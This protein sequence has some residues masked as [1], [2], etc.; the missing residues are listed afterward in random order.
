MMIM[1]KLLLTAAMAAA[2]GVG[3]L[4]TLVATSTAANAAVVCNSHGDC[5]RTTTTY[6]YRPAWGLHVYSNSWK[7][8]AAEANRYRW[9]NAQRTR[10][11]YGRNGVW[12]TF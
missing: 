7:W 12:I 4:G 11:Y 2:I 8:R 5:W 1:K 6:R 10:G 3:T 9:R